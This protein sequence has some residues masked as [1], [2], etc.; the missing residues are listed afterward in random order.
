ME[1]VMTHHV[2][3]M[4]DAYPKDL[5]NID[6]QKLA[7]CIEACFACAQACTACA[8]ACLA[9]DMVA[10]L[11]QCIRTDLDC[12]DVCEATGRVLSRQ[13][14]NTVEASR[15][16]LEACRTACRMCGDECASHAEMHEH[17]RVCAEA[18]RRCEQACADLLAA[19]G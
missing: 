1:D 7:E 6:R 5:G 12:A 17:C 2:S 19:M 4:L 10:D 16:L 11:R 8:D 15:A 18:C 13:T 14:G 9:E 3:A